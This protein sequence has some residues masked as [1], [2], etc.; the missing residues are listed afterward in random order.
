MSTIISC[1]SWKAA[2][3][4]PKL[5]PGF[6]VGLGELVGTLRDADTAQCN[7]HPVVANQGEQGAQPPDAGLVRQDDVV[8]DDFTRGHPVH[9][10]D[11]HL[12]HLEG[13]FFETHDE[14]GRPSLAVLDLARNEEGVGDG[15]VGGPQLA[16][17]DDP[18]VAHPGGGGRDP[19]C[20]GAGVGFRSRDRDHPARFQEVG[21]ARQLLLTE[22]LADHVVQ[23]EEHGRGDRADRR[24]DAV[25][26]V[27]LLGEDAGAIRSTVSSGRS[28]A[29]RA[30]SWAWTTWRMAARSAFVNGCVMSYSAS[31]G[32]RTLSMKRRTSLR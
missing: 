25:D 11:G 14:E 32:R 5:D 6:G 22:D 2:I 15:S 19:R 16:S 23:R 26:A 3:G 17:V 20:I 27:D 31:R 8:V 30:I 13:M 28:G 12:S 24:I 29:N 9:P 7:D 1:T 4:F 18:G 21:V 10:D